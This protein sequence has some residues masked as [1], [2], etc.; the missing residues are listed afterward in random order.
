MLLL[1][2]AEAGGAAMRQGMGSQ[3]TDQASD[4]SVARAVAAMQSLADALVAAVARLQR[5]RRGREQR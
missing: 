1:R 2:L 5:H 3:W 4:C